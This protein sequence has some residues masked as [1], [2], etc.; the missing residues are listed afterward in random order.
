MEEMGYTPPEKPSRKF[1]GSFIPAEIWEIFDEKKLTHEQWLLLVLIDSLVHSK[2]GCWGSNEYLAEKMH[3]SPRNIQLLLRP[4]IEKNYVVV[5][6]FDGR[7]RYLETCWSK[8]EP[9]ERAKLS[10]GRIARGTD[11]VNQRSKEGRNIKRSGGET[12]CAAD[13]EQVAPR[14]G[15]L[16]VTGSEEPVHSPQGKGVPTETP[17]PNGSKPF[18]LN[19]SNRPLT[20][21]EARA[22]KLKDVVQG[23]KGRAA[24]WMVKNQAKEFAAMR[25]QLGAELLDKVL[26]WYCR[27]LPNIK[28]RELPRVSSPSGFRAQWDWILDRYEIDNPPPKEEVVVGK[29][30]A[31]ILERLKS[32]RW[33][34]GSELELPAAV[35]RSWDAY[36][37]FHCGL[38]LV[39]GSKSVLAPFAGYVAGNLHDPLEF[40]VLWFEHIHDQVANWSRWSGRFDSLEFAV[41]HERFCGAGRGLSSDYADNPL[42]WDRLV[43]EVRNAGQTV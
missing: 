9:D 3:C 17:P 5:I 10:S 42:L 2:K 20:E 29:P 31:M 27:K 14:V 12:S 18:A 1:K 23:V 35:Q 4:L 39:I 25:K 15:T 38:D 34:K 43:K 6:G 36:L 26:D 16:R 22:K 13:L 21:D 24:S 32:R 41:D 8:V 28:G 33:P 19:G 37:A 30:A 40:V 7:T 11:A